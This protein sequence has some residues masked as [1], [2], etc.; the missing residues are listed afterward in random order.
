MKT[1]RSVEGRLSLKL[2]L[3]LLLQLLMRGSAD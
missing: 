2:L 1:H 3:L